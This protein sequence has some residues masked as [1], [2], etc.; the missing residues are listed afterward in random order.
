MTIMHYDLEEIVKDDHVLKQIEKIVSFR[1]IS[2]DYHDLA[3]ETGRKGYGV[4]IGI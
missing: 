4:E 1:K 2:H 3:K